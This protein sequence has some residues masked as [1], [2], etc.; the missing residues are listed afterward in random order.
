MGKTGKFQSKQKQR[1]NVSQSPAKASRGF[2]TIS[3]MMN[4]PPPAHTSKGSYIS[5]VSGTGK[6]TT[7]V[8]NS[9]SSNH[10]KCNGRVWKLTHEKLDECV[11]HLTLSEPQPMVIICA[12]D[13]VSSLVA[14]MKNLHSPHDS[15]HAMQITSVTLKTQRAQVLK[16]MRKNVLRDRGLIVTANECAMLTRSCVQELKGVYCKTLV[17]VGAVPSSGEIHRRAEMGCPTGADGSPASALAIDKVNHIYLVNK[18][19]A[20]VSVLSQGNLSAIT[21]YPVRKNWLPILQA[22]CSAARKLVVT[23]QNGNM[24]WGSNGQTDKDIRRAD[25]G[26]D[27]MSDGQGVAEEK[28]ALAG[29]IEGLRAKLK[30][31]MG[32]PL[33]GTGA[34]SNTAA[35]VSPASDIV[36]MIVGGEGK[37]TSTRLSVITESKKS[38][39]AK[40][41]ALGMVHIA[42]GEEK[43]AT[44]NSG[45]SL[46]ATRWMDHIAGCDI[47]CGDCSIES[48]LKWK[49]V[50]LGASMDN[51]VKNIRPIVEGFREF[52]SHRANRKMPK[53]HQEIE[54]FE[55]L[56]QVT[57]EILRQS[58][59]TALGW[60]PSPYG[61]GEWG[62][63]F[64]K[65]CGHNEVV[66]FYLRPFAPMEVLN[67]HICSKASPAPGNE[68]F[69]GCLEFLISQCKFFK[70]PMSVWDDRFFHYINSSGEH[71]AME[72]SSLLSLSNVRVCTLATNLRQLNVFNN[73]IHP[74]PVM[75][76]SIDFL[77]RIGTGIISIPALVQPVQGH[78]QKQGIIEIQRTIVSYV[79]SGSSSVLSKSL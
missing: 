4:R 65:C 40:M 19:A 38:R 2:V 50:R 18:E 22:R 29:R 43:Q 20:G 13:N 57:K 73:G 76:E 3:S 61:D 49:S 47:V 79:L 32:M 63:K 52:I 12:D 30:V 41:E 10:Q 68:G 44:S 48:P 77:I 72:K 35:S 7:S 45:R 60:R 67:T 51:A 8:G 16:M 39:R 27:D 70:R 9:G 42:S 23:M 28:R 62:G 64:G 11:Y 66:M 71:T 34:T 6:T 26:Y 46:A 21:T 15:T 36:P 55:T 75:I 33:P 25:L 56:P 54:F 1:G 31:T 37:N 74:V 58:R 53:K 69:D 78:G 14:T 59:I 5:S 17:H 24:L